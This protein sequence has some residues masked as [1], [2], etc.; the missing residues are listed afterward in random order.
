MVDSVGGIGPGQNVASGNNRAQNTRDDRRTEDTARANPVDEVEISQE[1]LNIA[2][3]EE[4]A[5]EQTASAAREQLAGD[6]GQ[7][8]GLD[9]GF[10]SAV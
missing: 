4:A 3:A 8:L 7:S 2:A 1:A 6:P 9:P 5:A 10:D